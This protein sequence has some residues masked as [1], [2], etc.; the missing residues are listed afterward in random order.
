MNPI[1]RLRLESQIVREIAGHLQRRKIKD[2]RIGFVSVVRAELAPDLSEAR[3]F[4]S[5]FGTESENRETWKALQIGRKEMQSTI[6]RALRLRQTP[7]FVF[8]KD[9]SIQEGDR[10]LGVMDED[11]RAHGQKPT[12][13]SQGEAGSD[14]DGPAPD[15]L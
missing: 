10:I 2:D 11:A 7:S 13:E 9:E 14:S 8:L 15:G 3:I 6:G 5:M 12:T 1:R 4:F